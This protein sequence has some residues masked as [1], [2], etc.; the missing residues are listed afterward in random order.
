MFGCLVV[1]QVE[2]VFDGQRDGTTGAEDHRE[3]IVYKLLQRPLKK[4]EEDSGKDSALSDV[5]IAGQRSGA[6]CYCGRH[7]FIYKTTGVFKQRTHVSCV[8]T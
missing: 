6:M 1:Q 7:P 4:Q 5:H 2:E 3:Q 8:R